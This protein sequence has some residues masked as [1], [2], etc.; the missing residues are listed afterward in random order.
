MI[1]TFTITAYMYNQFIKKYFFYVIVPLFILLFSNTKI[2]K[3]NYKKG[4]E[5]N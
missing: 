5:F 3:R 1:V 4:I 2:K